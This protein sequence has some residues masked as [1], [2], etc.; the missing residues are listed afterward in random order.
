VSVRI[1]AAGDYHHGQAGINHRR[2]RSEQPEPRSL[3]DTS[4]GLSGNRLFGPIGF[5]ARAVVDRANHSRNHPLPGFVVDINFAPHFS[6]EL[7]VLF[8]RSRYVR[9]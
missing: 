4:A 1:R 5:L 6:L 7:R 9:H 2:V 3:P 8:D